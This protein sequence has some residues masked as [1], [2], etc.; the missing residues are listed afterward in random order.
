MSAA[1]RSANRIQRR[2]EARK[3]RGQFVEVRADR[4]EAL[5]T[6]QLDDCTG[7]IGPSTLEHPPVTTR[8][9]NDDQLCKPG[10]CG[11]VR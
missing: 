3:G 11:C 6:T 1:T 9:T 2:G 8:V 4:H 5:D 10:E 7:E